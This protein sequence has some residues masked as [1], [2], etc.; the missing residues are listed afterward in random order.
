MPVHE[1]TCCGKSINCCYLVQV[2]SYAQQSLEKKTSLKIPFAWIDK[3]E[4]K[5]YFASELTFLLALILLKEEGKLCAECSKITEQVKD[6]KLN[7][8]VEKL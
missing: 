1:P 4:K 3:L 6:P 8:G 5:H 2:L 7:E